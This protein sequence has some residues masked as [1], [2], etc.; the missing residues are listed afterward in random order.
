[1][2]TLIA[3]TI[4]V[5]GVVVAVIN[6]AGA[7]QQPAMNTIEQCASLLPQGQVYTFEVM[8]IVDTTSGSPQLSGEMSISDGTE[9]DRSAET[10]AFGQCLARLIR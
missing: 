6:L 7:S 2:R 8:G 5:A 10:E 3:L 9:Q 1:M 4:I